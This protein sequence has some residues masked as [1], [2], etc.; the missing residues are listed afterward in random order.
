[1]NKEISKESRQEL[2]AAIRNSCVVPA[3]TLKAVEAA[4]NLFPPEDA[5][6]QFMEDAL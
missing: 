6:I 2:T 5:Y 3:A 1:M 4:A